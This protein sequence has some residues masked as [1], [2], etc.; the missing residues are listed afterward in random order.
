MV[1]RLERLVDAWFRPPF[2]QGGRGKLKLSSLL[3][4]GAELAGA[5]HGACR[6]PP[7]GMV[8]REFRAD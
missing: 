7:A 4:Y 1:A 8:A 5:P 3:S 6:P 2:L